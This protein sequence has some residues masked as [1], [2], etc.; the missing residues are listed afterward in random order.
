M[1]GDSICRIVKNIFNGGTIDEAICRTLIILIP[2]H[3]KPEG[4]NH[5][6]M[7]SPCNTIYKIITKVIAN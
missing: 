5:F 4:F 2:K 1:V 6:R 7:I 3:N